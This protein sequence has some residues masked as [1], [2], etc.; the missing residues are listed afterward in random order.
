[1]T[2]L[3]VA[4]ANLRRHPA[5]AA[6]CLGVCAIAILEFCFA[7]LTDAV[8]TERHLFIFHVATEI[9]VCFAA[10]WAIDALRA[11]IRT[12]VTKEPGEACVGRQRNDLELN[13]AGFDQRETGEVPSSVRGVAA[14]E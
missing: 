11:R 3:G 5:T 7:S 6:V 13:Q 8:E 14:F 2:V 4:L 12:S 1:V 10:A 9:T